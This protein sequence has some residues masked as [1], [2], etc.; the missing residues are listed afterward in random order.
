MIGADREFADHERMH[1]AAGDVTSKAKRAR[2]ISYEADGC[3]LAWV[4]FDRD[5]VAIDVQAMHHVRTDELD[6]DSITGI[7][8][9]L[10]WRIGELLRLRSGPLRSM[11]GNMPIPRLRSKSTRGTVSPCIS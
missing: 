11:R 3:R 9:E 10:G 4:G 2:S 5:A 6:R 7:D 8:F 1:R